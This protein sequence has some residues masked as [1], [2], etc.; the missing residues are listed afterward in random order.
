MTTSANPAGAP[1]IV[2]AVR[3][4]SQGRKIWIELDDGRE[5]GF[6][7]DRFPR[8]NNAPD[9]LLAEVKLELGGRALRWEQLDED[10]TVEGIIAGRWHRAPT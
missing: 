2:R 1:P 9:H 6:P 4:W 7:A 8:L 5:V 3:A 10:L